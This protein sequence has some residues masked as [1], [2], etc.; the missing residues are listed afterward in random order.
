MNKCC[1]C[2][3][4]VDENEVDE[5]DEG[6]THAVCASCYAFDENYVGWCTEEGCSEQCTCQLCTEP[7][8]RC[9]GRYCYAHAGEEHHTCVP[10]LVGSS[11][12]ERESDGERDEEE[13]EEEQNTQ[14]SQ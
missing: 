3:K 5:C 8:E 11:D 13:Q 2:D 4:Q 9:E 10:S 12:S 7:C 14:Q 1:F 6:G